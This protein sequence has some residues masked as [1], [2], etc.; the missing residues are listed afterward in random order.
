V[1]ELAITVAEQDTKLIVTFMCVHILLARVE[2]ERRLLD[3]DSCVEK[4]K[5]SIIERG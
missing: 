5:L 4:V 1:L 2:E 3:L